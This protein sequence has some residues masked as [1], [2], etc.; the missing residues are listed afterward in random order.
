MALIYNCS[1]NVDNSADTL[2]YW[3]LGGA[4]QWTPFPFRATLRTPPGTDYLATP[5]I[6]TATPKNEHC[7]QALR[8]PLCTR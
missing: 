1:K 6:R 8:E 3:I 2:R 7:G 4:A 5:I